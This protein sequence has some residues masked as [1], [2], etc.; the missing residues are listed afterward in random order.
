MCGGR[1][2]AGGVEPG[3]GGGRAG[4]GFG[5]EAVGLGGAAE[6]A[7]PHRVEGGVEGGAELRVATCKY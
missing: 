2:V 6:G 4:V 1:G 3:Q 5:L 7:V